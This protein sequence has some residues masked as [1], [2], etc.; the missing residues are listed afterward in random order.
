MVN[1]RSEIWG[2][3]QKFLKTTHKTTQ[4]KKEK[5]DTEE[6]NKRKKEN[7]WET[8]VRDIQESFI[9]KNQEDA[10]KNKKLKGKKNPI[11]RAWSWANI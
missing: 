11:R 7:F 1:Q 8:S 2:R 5:K 4:K 6:T 9:S 3:P 10:M